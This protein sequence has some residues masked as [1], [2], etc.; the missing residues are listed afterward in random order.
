MTRQLHPRRTSAVFAVLLALLL[1]GFGLR[2][3]KLGVQSFWYDEGN[4]ARIA[5]RSVPLII[6]G[7]AGDIHPPLYYLALHYW[8]AAAGDSETALRMLSVVS[9]VLLIAVAALLARDLLN[10]LTGLAAAAL[11]ALS[12]FAVYY[13]QEARMYELLAL[14]ASVTTWALVRLASPRPASATARTFAAGLYVLG[15][16]AGLYTQYAYPFVMVAQGVCVVIW[17]AGGGSAHW[18]SLLV[19]ALLNVAAIDLFIPWLPIAV[20]Q[21]AS[22]GVAP[23]TYQLAQAALDAYRWLVVGRTLDLGQATLPLTAISALALAGLL[24][25]EHWRAR[26]FLLVLALLPFILLFAFKL[27]REAYL[28][29]LLVC[30]APWLILAA[31][32]IANA[33]TAAANWLFKWRQSLPHRLAIRPVAAA[34]LTVAAALTMQPSLNNLYNNP[35]YA[36]DDYRGIARMIESGAQPGDAVLLDA[37]NQWEVFTYYHRRGAPAIPLAYRPVSDNAVASQM[38]PIVAQYT[39]LFV[40]YYGE[41]ESDPGGLFE[42]WLA[43]HAYKADE[44]W[45]GNIRLVVY[46][47]QA[48]AQTSSITAT[49]GDSIALVSAQ[50]TGGEVAPGGLVPVSLAWRALARLTA[51]YK[52][53]LHI[54]LPDAPPVAQN[55]AEPV[56]GFRPTS[57]WAPGETIIDQRAVWVR[58]DAPPGRYGLYVGLYD[59]STGQ[60]LAIDTSHGTAM[61]GRLYLGD[62]TIATRR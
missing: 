38:Q 40:L 59:P 53:F 17:L 26:V 32:G 13:S 25:G 28:K 34:I 33:A 41:R 29:F 2:M 14:Q 44:Q 35:A 43:Q 48:P 18:R 46:A 31:H 4:S 9:G 19:Y 39:R 6:A 57:S 56:G 58:A 36:R 8:R 3:Y 50:I 45:V 30:A 23:Q 10:P 61:A 16:A 51:R 37:P 21:I 1:L 12:P 55:D 20:R 49:F 5:E 15:T 52:V 54:G 24:S 42:R 60:R 27:Y 62:I 7:A 47:T 22:W 11:V